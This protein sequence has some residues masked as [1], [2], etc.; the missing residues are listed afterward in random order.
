V[1]KIAV[2]TKQLATLTRSLRRAGPESAAATRGAIR[3]AGEIVAEEARVR[4][5]FSSRIEW[6]IKSRAAGGNFKVTAG[7]EAAPNAAPI[8]NKGRGHVRHPVYGDRDV[9]TEKNSPPA[10][11]G[12]A[13]DA[14]ADEVAELVADRLA[15]AFTRALGG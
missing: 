12:P 13:L 3:D 1:A 10:Y 9:W 8:E 4:S 14:K 2:D 11:L 15:Q 5:S 6:S 7:G